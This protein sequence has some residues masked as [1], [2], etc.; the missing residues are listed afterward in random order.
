MKDFEFQ[1][2]ECNI[3]SV[4]DPMAHMKKKKGRLTLTGNFESMI[5]GAFLGIDFFS[6]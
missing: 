6:S 1:L 5:V 2:K 3:Y 4:I